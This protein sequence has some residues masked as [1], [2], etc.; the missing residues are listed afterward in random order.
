MLIS[1]QTLPQKYF[2]MNETCLTRLAGVGCVGRRGRRGRPANIISFDPLPP[3]TPSS[4]YLGLYAFG[5]RAL[6]RSGLV[7]RKSY[8]LQV[9]GRRE[10]KKILPEI[11]LS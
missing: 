5:S 9:E 7:Y 4:L 11:R 8:A 2:L 1:P 10:R 6:F 3:L